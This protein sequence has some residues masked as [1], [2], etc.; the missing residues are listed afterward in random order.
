MT[1][2]LG[3]PESPEKIAERHEPLPGP[4]A[5]GRRRCSRSSRRR[6]ARASGRSA[7]GSA[8]RTEGRSTRPDGWCCPSSRA[9]ASR[10][11]ATSAGHRA[12]AERSAKH[13]YLYAYPVR[14]QRPVE[15]DLPQARLRARRRGRS[16]STRR[17]RATSCAATT[18]ASSSSAPERAL[19]RENPRFLYSPASSH[20]Y[21]VLTRGGGT[22]ERP[23]DAVG[24]SAGRGWARRCRRDVRRR[25][26]LEPEHGEGCCQD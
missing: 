16:T 3:G 20:R 11:I 15:R 24:V 26:V 7:T 17:A 12:R 2:H 10:R 8:S 5:T 25:R 14:G 22:Y 4:E 21:M 13:R 23:T 18:G 19:C 1:E 9:A 6:R